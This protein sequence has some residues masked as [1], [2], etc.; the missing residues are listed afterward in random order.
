[1]AVLKPRSRTVTFR[2]STEEFLA[3]M[4]SCQNSESRSV[5]DFA[6]AAVLHKIHSGPA[7]SPG[8]TTSLPQGNF[9]HLGKAL[10]ELDAALG[11]VS[12]AIRSLP[13]I[14]DRHR[15]LTQ[16]GEQNGYQVAPQ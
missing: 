16:Q 6:R 15:R 5:S 10:E 9:G 1:M 2:V 11:D 7:A 4:E 8:G 14:S 12:R 3:L 13:P